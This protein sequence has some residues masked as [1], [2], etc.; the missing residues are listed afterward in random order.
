MFKLK[1][2]YDWFKVTSCRN[3]LMID[4]ETFVSMSGKGS[5]VLR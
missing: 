2:Q 1:S 5:C 4:G 3:T